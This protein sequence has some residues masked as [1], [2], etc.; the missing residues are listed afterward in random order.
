MRRLLC[1]D[2]EGEQTVFSSCANC[3]M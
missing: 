3:D 2:F 1:K